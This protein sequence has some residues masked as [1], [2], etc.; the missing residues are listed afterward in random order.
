MIPKKFDS[1]GSDHVLRI[2]DVGTGTRYAILIFEDPS[3]TNY[4]INL[5]AFAHINMSPPFPSIGSLGTK[6]I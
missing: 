3:T 5:V 1:D 4:L 6:I 2:A